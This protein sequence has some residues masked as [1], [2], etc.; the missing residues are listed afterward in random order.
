MPAC[1]QRCLPACREHRDRVERD[2]YR[3]VERERERERERE[4]FA[5]VE[6]ERETFAGVERER[7]ICRRGEREIHLPAC[8]CP[9]DIFTTKLPIEVTMQHQKILNK[10]KLNHY[11]DRKCI[12]SHMIYQLVFTHGIFSLKR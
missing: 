2:V 8:T 7:D 11:N 5:G 6:R 1:R 4:T 9:A 12:K 3:R 10:T